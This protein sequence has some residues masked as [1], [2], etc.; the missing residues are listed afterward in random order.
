VDGTSNFCVN[1]YGVTFTTKGGGNIACYTCTIITD[2]KN[3]SVTVA[4]N[5]TGSFSSGSG[6]YSSNANSLIVFR[7]EKT[8]NLPIQEA[9]TY[10]VSYHL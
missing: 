5:A 7:I 1:D 3:Q 6:S 10:T 8:C 9:V 2:K 4:G